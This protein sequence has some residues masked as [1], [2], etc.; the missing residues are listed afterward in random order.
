MQ[1]LVT[2]PHHAAATELDTCTRRRMLFATRPLGRMPC[3]HASGA[4]TRRR[5]SSLVNVAPASHH[6]HH[7]RVYKCINISHLL[8]DAGVPGRCTHEEPQHLSQQ[9]LRQPRRPGVA[10]H[11]NQAGPQ[12]EQVGSPHTTVVRR[13]WLCASRGG[14][15]IA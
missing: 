12:H 7:Q 11:D 13:V 2:H 14:G 6:H 10:A 3:N 5:R 8:H 1:P 15:G 9:Q 4:R